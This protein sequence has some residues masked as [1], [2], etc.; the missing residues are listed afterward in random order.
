MTK[1]WI[2]LSAIFVFSVGSVEQAVASDSNKKPLP[3]C[4]Q[5][6]NNE[7][8][9]YAEK[10]FD[11]RCLSNEHADVVLEIDQSSKYPLAKLRNASGTRADIF[12]AEQA[13]W[14]SRPLPLQERQSGGE[15]IVFG[16]FGSMGNFPELVS[17]D[18]PNVV[19]LHLIPMSAE[20]LC[21]IS[22]DKICSINNVLK[23]SVDKTQDPLLTEF[24]K[25][26]ID[27]LSTHKNCSE[28]E[29]L[30]EGKRLK[31]KYEKLFL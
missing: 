4:L 19:K 18:E 16:R 7:V 20:N 12:Y 30:E 17:K 5:A 24:R 15:V 26:W 1:M 9:R 3:P 8:Q 11:F 25:E 2:L 21:T 6:S 13:F 22:S 14:E 31:S 27:F 10:F 29:V 28:T 23:L